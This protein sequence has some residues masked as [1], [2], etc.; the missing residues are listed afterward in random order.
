MQDA[1]RI[2]CTRE[3]QNSLTESS[4]RLLADQVVRLGHSD[5]YTVQKT[6]ITG[7]NGTVFVFAG[8]RHHVTKIKSFEG[9]DIVWVEEGQ[10]EPKRCSR[11]R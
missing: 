7:V 8:L 10:V 4:H 3:F 2:L 9:A 1:L 6:M 5:F 11:A